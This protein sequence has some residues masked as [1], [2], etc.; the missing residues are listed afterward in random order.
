M[1]TLIEKLA[2]EKKYETV[3]IDPNNNEAN[4]SE[5]NLESLNE[6]DVAIEF[7]HPTSAIEN[8]HKL[9]EHNIPVVAGV[10]GWYDT[11]DEIKELVLKNDSSFVYA[12]NFSLGVQLYFKVIEQTAKLFN[13]FSEFDVAGYE[14]HHNQKADSPSGTAETI[15]KKLLENID[16]KDKVVIDS[17]QEKIKENELSFPALRVGSVPGTHAVLF[18]SSVDTIEIKHTARNREGFALGSIQAAEWLIGKKGFYTVDD[19]INSIISGK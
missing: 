7:S 15:I 5:I 10:T 13:S 18:D 1:G 6:V 14:F 4:F 3:S 17:P 19:L 9:I 11:V 16:R 12:G 2:Q 8:F